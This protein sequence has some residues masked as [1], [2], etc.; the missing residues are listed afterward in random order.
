MT[1]YFLPK[2]NPDLNVRRYYYLDGVTPTCRSDYTFSV[3]NAR[4]VEDW[5]KPEQAGAVVA[6]FFQRFGI[7]EKLTHGLTNNI[8]IFKLN[9][10]Q[11]Y[12]DFTFFE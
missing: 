7:V 3:W 6:G 4:V 11:F 8:D 9:R 2:K 1:Y 12:I 10:K 5:V